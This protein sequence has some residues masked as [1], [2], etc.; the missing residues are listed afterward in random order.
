M[1]KT[2]VITI[3]TL[4]EMPQQ[5]FN[6]TVHF[7]LG[8]LRGVQKY[9]VNA[10]DASMASIRAW[11]ELEREMIDEGVSTHDCGCCVQPVSIGGD[12][13][14]LSFEVVEL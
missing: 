13:D 10:L 8:G 9:L 12:H 7:G 1:T 11:R 6:V 14:H 2:A 4:G 3:P 5:L